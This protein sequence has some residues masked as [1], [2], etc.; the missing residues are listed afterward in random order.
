MNCLV[1]FLLNATPSVTT[2]NQTPATISLVEEISINNGAAPINNN[3]NITFE[4]SYTRAQFGITLVMKPTIHDPDPEQGVEDTLIT[5]DT[6]VTFDTPL[7]DR[8]D[9]PVINRRHIENQVRVVDGQTVILGGLR[10][11]SQ[12]SISTKIPFLGEIP[13]IAK[14]FGSTKMNDQMTETFVFITPKVIHDVKQDLERYRNELLSKRP[15]DLPEFCDRLFE[16][17]TKQKQK[18]FAQSFNLFFGSP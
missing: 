18:L 3:Q 16:A 17:E 6:N 2:I 12:D 7:S 8:D 9:R 14:L 11:K 4:N 13:G 5:L 10:R 1:S 15:G